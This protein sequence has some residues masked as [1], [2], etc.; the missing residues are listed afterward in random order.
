MTQAEPLILDLAGEIWSENPEDI[1]ASFLSATEGDLT[2]RA[3]ASGPIN[4]QTAQILLSAKK[5]AELRGSDLRIEAPSEALENSLRIL[6]LR[7]VLLEERR[8][9]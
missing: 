4:A 2:I 1:I 8:A 5:L 6:G 7:A 3:E 9:P